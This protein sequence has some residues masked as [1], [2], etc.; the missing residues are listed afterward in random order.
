[1]KKFLLLSALLAAGCCGMQAQDQKPVE[2]ARASEIEQ[3]RSEVNA[4]RSEKEADDQKNLYK[5]IFGRQKTF[6]IGMA[7]NDFKP[8]DG[9]KVSANYGFMMGL[10]KTYFVHPNPI[11]GFVKFGIEATWFDITY[12]NYK[13]FGKVGLGDYGDIINGDY[14]GIIDNYDPDYGYD[15]DEDLEYDLDLGMHQIDLGMGVGVSATFAPFYRHS[16]AL[17]EL[18]FKAYVNFMPTYSMVLR[19]DKN[20]EGD[21]EVKF[22]GA[23]VPYFTCGAQ[24]S[25][26]VLSLFVEGRWGSANYKFTS[27]DDGPSEKVSCSNSGVRFGIGL[28]F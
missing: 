18:K 9:E 6:K 2:E 24:A 5:H 1:M 27:F 3:L 4:L 12:I 25:W 7:F 16:N 10:T 8:K 13:D 22:S 28:S 17:N 15:P 19:S 23:F 20:E 11:G 14:D 26:K 21:D